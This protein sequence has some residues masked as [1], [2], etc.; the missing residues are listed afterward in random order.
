MFNAEQFMQSTY[1]EANSTRLKPVPPGE[2]VGVIEPIDA[3]NF[4]S[5]ISQK[6]GEPWARLDVYIECA[7]QRI[8]DACGV[9]SRRI[10]A[11]IMLDMTPSGGLDM[12]EGKNITLG[13]LREA[14]GL[15]KPGQ[16]FSFPQLGGKLVKISVQHRPDP[17]DA[18]IIYEDVKAFFP[19]N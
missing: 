4:S 15:N 8:Q 7:D 3:K 9:P 1:N 11:G 5:G 13:R 19:A 18:S 16:P 10:K 12:S 6:T 17:K 2:Y 14:V